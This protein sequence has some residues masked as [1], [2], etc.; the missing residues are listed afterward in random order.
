[1]SPFIRRVFLSRTDRP[2]RLGPGQH[3]QYSLQR[4]PQFSHRVIAVALGQDHT[5]ALTSEKEVLSWGLNRFSQLGYVVE[6]TTPTGLLHIKA[7]E[8]PI[9]AVARKVLGPLKKEAVV[10]VAAC[11]TASACWTHKDV[12]TWGTNNGQLGT[13]RGSFM[14]SQSSLTYGRVRQGRPADANLAQESDRCAVRHGSSH[15]GTVQQVT[16]TV[17]IQLTHAWRRIQQ[18]CAF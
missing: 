12:F 15:I 14:S 9:Q 3:T 16:F 17:V 8:E 11:K 6:Q 18:W 7:M 10:G 1:M 4:V 2:D 13:S 5:L